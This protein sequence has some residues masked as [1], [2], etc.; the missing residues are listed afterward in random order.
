MYIG[1]CLSSARIWSASFSCGQQ[2][3]IRGQPRVELS[4]SSRHE[5]NVTYVVLV[6]ECLI[7]NGGDIKQGVPQTQQDTAKVG[8]FCW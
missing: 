4:S 6:Q 8:H 7:H 5:A 2:K 1:T 3:R